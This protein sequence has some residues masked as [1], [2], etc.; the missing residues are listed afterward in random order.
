M[1][2]EIPHAPPDLAIAKFTKELGPSIEE[3]ILGARKSFEIG[4]GTQ[5]EAFYRV[6]LK[7][8]TPPKGGKERIAHGEAC[9]FFALKAL[10]KGR[11]GEAGDWYR[12][13]I[14]SD[15]RA[16]DYRVE[17]VTKVLTLMGLTEAARQEATR[18]VKIDPEDA[19]AWR[20]LGGVEY[21]SGNTK[22]ATYAYE[23]AFK[24]APDIPSSYLD[25]CALA[26]DT[27]DYVR[28]EELCKI[29]EE[30]FPEHI[31][32]VQQCRAMV[33]YRES[34]FEEAIELYTKAIEGDCHDSEMTKWNR[35]LPLQAIGRYKEG[36]ADAEARGSQKTSVEFGIALRRFNVPLLD[37][38]KHRPPAR[39][40]LHEEM[41]FGDTFAMLRYIPLLIG[42]GYDVR[43]EVREQ[44]LPLVQRSFPGARVMEKAADYPGA[45][46]IPAFDYHHSLL[47]LPY[48]FGTA[49]DTIP[50]S[51]PYLKP[52]PD[53]VRY[54]KQLLRG[55]K[56][57]GLVWSAGIRK[58]IWLTEYGQR[59]SMSLRQLT[60]VC[61]SI[62]ATFISL[63]VGPERSELKHISGVYDLLPEE[64]T[65]DD[66]A[67]L[68][69]NLDLV[70]TVDTAVSHL[71]GALGKPTW[72]MWAESA[73]SWHYMTQ[74]TDS[75]WY[76]N[77]RVF[78]QKKAHEWSDVIVDISGAL[79]SW[80]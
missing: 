80:R 35:S 59:K 49:V 76:P 64:P 12:E 15:P 48:V 58:G 31:P 71:S 69:Q 29:I 61:N 70:I 6:L 38:D 65:W 1:T 20:T 72:V 18:A 75:P 33:A 77:S 45:L 21:E 51:G 55:K 37:L 16:T 63:Q 52:D 66:T 11:T 40:H 54:W 24:L 60:N 43:V 36:W 32:D 25:L 41:G 78:R 46:G 42:Q 3:L 62:D 10:H 73:A 57:I 68:I 19:R 8:T 79:Y 2:E 44:I 23:T 50:W 26:L 4:F 27:A 13:A 67:A 14:N 17:L 47:S 30:K 7:R 28:V 9:R 74:G 22:E 5:A 56:N 53:R 34:R 39:L